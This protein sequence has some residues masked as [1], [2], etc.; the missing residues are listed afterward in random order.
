MVRL[1]LRGEVCPFTFVRTKLALEELA[2]GQGLDVFVDHAPA[3]ENV[4]RSLRAEGQE[5]V[6][7][8]RDG[9]GWLIRAIKRADHPLHRGKKMTDQD[10]IAP[11]GGTLVDRRADARRAGELK[12]RASRLPQIELHIRELADLEMIA[13]GALSPL[14][15]F[16]GPEDYRQVVERGRLANGL[17]WTIPVTLSV[18]RDAKLGVGEEV[19]LRDTDGTVRAIIEVDHIWEPN[20]EREAQ[21]VYGTTEQKH[22]GVAQ[23]YELDDLYVGGKVWL[24]EQRPPA[25]PKHHNEPAQTRRYFRERGWQRIAAFQTRNPIH[26][27]HEYLTKVA[28]E[29]ADGLLIHPLVGYTKDDDIPADVR[30]RCYEALLHGYYPADRVLL[31]TLPA[32]MRYAGPKEAIFHALMRKN[33]GCTHF[34]VG[35]DH[36]GVGSYYGTY[37]A[38]REFDKYDPAEIGITPLRF[39]NSFYCNKCGATVSQKTC[40]HTDADRVILSGTKVRELLRSGQEPPPE[41][42]RPEVARILIEAMRAR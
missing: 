17:P 34:I 10:A 28:L 29:I 35:R 7:V 21:S 31:S 16:M 41:F 13:T 2:L 25:F 3:A 38:Q 5:V 8:N 23:L 24:F 37:D 19:A 15:G 42:S 26:R 40:P 1:D 11:H 30:M 39:E 18:P 6:S 4:P 33:Y 14:E 12:E 27:A 22:P 36:A 32:A 20:R 9:A